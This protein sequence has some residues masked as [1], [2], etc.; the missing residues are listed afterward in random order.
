MKKPLCTLLIVVAIFFGLPVVAQQAPW[1][2]PRPRGMTEEHARYAAS[3]LEVY[4]RLGADFNGSPTHFHRRIW[5]WQGGRNQVTPISNMDTA[6]LSRL[7]SGRYFVYR[8]SDRGDVW[9]VQYHDPDGETHFCVGQRDGSYSEF[10]MDRY[11]HRAAFGLSG[12]FY[13][14]PQEQGS[15]RPDLGLEYAWPV[16]ANGQTGQIAVYAWDDRRWDMSIGWLQAEYA[17]GF[18]ENCP[19]LPRASRVNNNQSGAT[20]QEMALG[21]RAITGFRTGFENDPANPLTV[22]MFYWAY[23]PE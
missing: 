7:L 10:T 4:N 16:V 2:A 9:S 3:A 15:A 23:P 5:T 11:V 1:D 14:D 18:A 20:I 6:D 19:N 12:V 8:N 21:A 17:A 22:G 13:W